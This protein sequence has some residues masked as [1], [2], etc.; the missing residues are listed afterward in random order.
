MDDRERGAVT[1][2]FAVVLPVVT[3][4][5]A[6]LLVIASCAVAQ[7]RCADAARA[8]ARSAAIGEP[9]QVVAEVAE[10]V[11]GGGVRVAVHRTDGW[12]EVVVHRDL[13]PSLPVVGAITVSAAAT[14]WAEP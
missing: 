10:R 8:G 12:V 9:D 11:G 3:L 2:E 7:M 6:A 13:G 4:L 5:I 14:A 1:A